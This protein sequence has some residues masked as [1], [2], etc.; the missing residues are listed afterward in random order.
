MAVQRA[1]RR[2]LLNKMCH[3]KKGEA[4]TLRPFLKFTKITLVTLLA[5][6]VVPFY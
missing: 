5:F 3:I 4:I 2:F 1:S 6:Q